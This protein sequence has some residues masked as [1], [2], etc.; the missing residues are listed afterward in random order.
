MIDAS[1]LS[2]PHDAAHVASVLMWTSVVLAAAMTIAVVAERALVALQ[3]LRE[4]R[5]ERRYHPLVQRALDGDDQARHALAASPSRHR[6]A[7]AWLLI[8]P[9]IDD[10]APE[11][12]ERT[13]AIATVISL[14][15]LADRYL[16][17]WWWWRRALALR[18]L[19]LV[20]MRDRATAI[21]AALDDA[22]TDVR[23][24]ALDALTDL[25][26]PATLPA[27]VVRLHDGSL[28]GGR[29][30]A[31]LAAFGPRCEEFLLDL[32]DVDP[33]N[34]AAYARALAI[35]GTERSRPTLARWTALPRPE[36]QAAAFEALSNV[37]LDESTAW[38]AMAALESADAAVRAMAARALHGWTGSGDAA[39]RLAAHL[40]DEW[41]VA[42]NAAR[43]LRSLGARGQLE[44]QAAAG[45]AD[46]PGMLAREMLWHGSLQW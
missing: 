32:A 23:A 36:L 10:R 17:S 19:G 20:Q 31:A 24:A 5:I 28:H 42:V 1:L 30:A 34:R 27:I 39:T 29:R 13:R 40:D 41:P 11:R 7:I 37:G 8:G 3:Q 2:V 25:E 38:C 12:V 4:H 26:D 43:S 21:I 22:N 15:P 18:A 44:L 6:V 35:C 33:D 9:L 14:V 46:L 45:R 16:R